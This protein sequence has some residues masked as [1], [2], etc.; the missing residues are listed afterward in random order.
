MYTNRVRWASNATA[1]SPTAN[2]QKSV[3]SDKSREKK[4]C[5]VTCKVL[6]ERSF[7]KDSYLFYTWPSEK[8]T[9][10]FIQVLEDAVNL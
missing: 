10:I 1:S 4:Y 9:T 7:A 2:S 8:K 5:F 3:K 6:K